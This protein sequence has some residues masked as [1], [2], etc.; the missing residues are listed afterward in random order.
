MYLLDSKSE[1]DT[2]HPNDL[3]VYNKLFLSH[4]LG[5]LCG[6]AGV[7][8]PHSGT[9]IVRPSLNLLG[10]GRFSR[11]E[12]I[13]SS[14]DHLHPSEFWCQ[15]FEGE[16]LSVDFHYKNPQLVVKGYRKN[17]NPLYKWDK[18][19][20]INRN[21]QFPSILNELVGNYEWINCEFVNNH[22]IEVHFR[23]NPDFRYGNSVA[24][25]IWSDETSVINS[26][27]RY[28][29]DKDYLRKGFLID[30]GIETP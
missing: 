9:Y 10:M 15:I 17:E 28:I 4:R 7:P 27:Y 12:Y 25:P 5:Y 22:L 30:N 16:H 26:E 19:E 29:K 20:K 21:I 11:F 3:W 24:I 8:V 6:P 23:Q 14:T 13:E 2:I 18:W 1:W